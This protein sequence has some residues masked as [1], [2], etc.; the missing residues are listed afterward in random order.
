MTDLHGIESSLIVCGGEPCLAG[1]RI[2]VWTLEQA[3]RLGASET[4][5][6]RAY[7]ALRPKNLA[8]ARNYVRLHHEEINRQIQENEDA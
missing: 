4:E 5:L 2:P 3:N 6:L 1:T 8:L 7:P